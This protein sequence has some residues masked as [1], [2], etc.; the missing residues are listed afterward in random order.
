[1]LILYIGLNKWHAYYINVVHLI[2][3]WH[4]QY[5]NRT[6]QF[7]Y[8]GYNKNNFSKLSFGTTPRRDSPD[9]ITN[10][11]PLLNQSM[12]PFMASVSCLFE[13][14]NCPAS[15]YDEHQKRLADIVDSWGFLLHPVPGDGNCCF[16]ALAFSI[17]AQ[18]QDLELR[19]AQIFVYS[20]P[21]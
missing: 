7:T 5:T 16:Y 19:I 8:T 12:I 10:H 14:V 13:S 4:C 1:M 20:V 11:S 21:A 6:V 15:E 3:K 9:N 2:Y 18:R 17:H